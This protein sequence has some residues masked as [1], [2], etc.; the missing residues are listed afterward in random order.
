MNM[1]IL[2]KL[3]CTFT[4][5]LLLLNIIIFI[6]IIN[7]NTKISLVKYI[8]Y[9]SIFFLISI[10][11]YN[12]YFNTQSKVLM[13]GLILIFYV[14]FP[15]IISG[16]STLSFSRSFYIYFLIS[17]SCDLI[18]ALTCNIFQAPDGIY[19]HGIALAIKFVILL[20]LLLLKNHF[21]FDK[22]NEIL[23]I[24]PKTIYIL[25]A[26]NILLM[27]AIS[28]VITYNTENLNAQVASINIV[29]LLIFAISTIITIS[30][31]SNCI[32]KTYYNSINSILEKQIKS[33]IEH[34]KQTE[35]LNNDLRRFRHD[36]ANH[37]LCLKSMIKANQLSEAEEY[38]EQINS[39][40]I[41]SIKLFNTGH[42]IADAIL[43]EKSCA[44]T[45][46]GIKFDGFIPDSLNN[47][48][49]CIILGNAVDN[50]IEACEKI[51]SKD[52]NVSIT[53]NVQQGHFILILT[54]PV[55]SDMIVNEIFPKTTKS[56]TM[57]HGFGLSN[58]K[59]IV[60]KYEGDV[61]TEIKNGIF[62]LYVAIKINC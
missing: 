60:D 13:F 52:R 36:Y 62:I 49:L 17:Q 4:D 9:I 43:N 2:E 58:I 18:Q 53:A 35:S 15:I 26:V 19:K 8:I 30:L 46:I 55:D 16:L 11:F 1:E 32:S 34:Y 27:G 14:R 6:H 51:K 33:Q 25:I 37:M 45:D 3:L 20:L 47:T 40:T 12:F 50:A 5:L 61:S 24:I 44:H 29:L 48:D 56:D 41:S 23:S 21:D 38:I 10:L 57:K 22:F 59:R 54:N 31:I 7:K 28:S 39:E 42:K